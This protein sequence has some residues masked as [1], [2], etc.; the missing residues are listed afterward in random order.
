MK[1]RPARRT[2]GILTA[3]LVVAL[4]AP[5]AWANDIDPSEPADAAVVVDEEAAPAAVGEPTPEPAPVVEDE[6]PAAAG[7]TDDLAPGQ[8]DETPAPALHQQEPAMALEAATPDSDTL[9]ELP[10][11]TLDAAEV[12]LTVLLGDADDCRAPVVAVPAGERFAFEV[13]EDGGRTWRSAGHFAVGDTRALLLNSA[14]PGAKIVVRDAGPPPV[15]G[16]DWLPTVWHGAVYVATDDGE[17]YAT[18]YGRGQ[19]SWEAEA[20]ARV[21]LQLFLCPTP[22]AV[23]PV[24]PVDPE[25]EPVDP[26]PSEP[27]TDPAPERPAHRQPPVNPQAEAPADHTR[28]DGGVPAAT[29]SPALAAGGV[30]LLAAAALTARHLTNRRQRQG[31]NDTHDRV[32]TE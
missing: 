3:A 16:V 28:I 23:D 27:G 17:M 5:T 1:T 31:D 14:E 13:S 6:A 12:S 22:A 10:P 25:P 8:L 26:E 20:N 21:D 29:T 32:T 19:L 4:T 30:I 2:L 9:A 15:E 18:R 11:V 7:D 24:P